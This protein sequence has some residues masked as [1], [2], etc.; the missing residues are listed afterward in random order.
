MEPIK[1]ADLQLVS[2]RQKLVD[3]LHNNI[4]LPKRPFQITNE[5][6]LV[7]IRDNDYIVCPRL[8]G[9]VCW[10]LFCKFDN[11]YYAVN[12]P[13]KNPRHIH[14]INIGVV[15]DFYSGTIMEGVYYSDGYNHFLVID[16]V[17]LFA[18]ATQLLKS[19]DDRLTELAERINK[20]SVNEYTYKMHVS[21]YYQ[22]DKKNLQEL[23]DYIKA[24]EK[25]REIMFYPK[26]YG[27]KIYRYGIMN[28]DIVDHVIKNSKFLLQ[29]TNNPDVYN[30][31]LLTGEKI[32]IAY[33]PDIETSKTCKRWF[34][35]SSKDEAILVKCQYHFEMKKWIP[36]DKL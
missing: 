30:L 9:T 3:Y 17:Y 22:I 23:F 16:E 18:G 8:V 13:K 15:K 1:N 19:K 26:I 4:D 24:D 12:F 36:K 33:I 25:V 34:K 5:Q 7:D 29:K 32:D 21:K 28:Y 6:D 35:A 31:L 10:I 14:P 20:D 2:V 27:R 11:Y